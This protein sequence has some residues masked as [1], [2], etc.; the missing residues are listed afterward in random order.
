MPIHSA[1][2][3]VLN[4]TA[5][6]EQDKLVYLLTLER[7]IIKA[8]A[9]GA[10]KSKNRFGAMLEVFTL[11]NFWY[12]GTDEKE[13]A[14]L[15]KGE[16]LTSFFNTVSR[17]EN[18]FTFFLM[19]EILLKM[20]PANQ[21][22]PRIFRL[23]H[24]ILKARE[25]GAD[26]LRLLLYF[27][28]WILR[29]EGLMFNP[30]ICT[31]CLRKNLKNAWMK[32]DFRGILC[33]QCRKHEPYHLNQLELGYIHWTASVPPDSAYPGSAGIRTNH[34]NRLFLKKIEY[35]AECSFKSRQYLPGFL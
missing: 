4:H 26:M 14:T 24:A 17:P 25:T 31:N 21:R 6:N 29:I 30:G 7:G 8:V 10:L 35:H 23:V 34:M 15:S 3:F 12:Y 5:I 2:A 13:M 20:I 16:I 33:A 11:G 22:D 19:A 1:Q 27:Q 9:P 18:I 28:V 32:T